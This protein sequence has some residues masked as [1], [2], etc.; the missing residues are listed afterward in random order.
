MQISFW[1]KLYCQ[2]IPHKTPGG[3]W[4]MAVWFVWLF[5][6]NFDNGNGYGWYPGIIDRA[7]DYYKNKW[8]E[9]GY[10]IW[11]WL[12]YPASQKFINKKN[13]VEPHGFW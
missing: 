7:D 10:T 11:A 3:S 9:A 5:G 1:K 13:G 6:G 4:C 8:N 2:N 12:R